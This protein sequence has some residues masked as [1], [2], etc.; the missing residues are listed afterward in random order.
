[1]SYIALLKFIGN[2]IFNLEPLEF[3][4]DFEPGLQKAIKTVYPGAKLTTCW[5]HYIRAI[6]RRCVKL[7]MRK[8]IR[9]NFNARTIQKQILNLPLLP[10]DCI[11]EG[12]NIIKNFAKEL[13]LSKKF[14]NFFKYFQDYWLKKVLFKYVM[15][16][17][18]K[19]LVHL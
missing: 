3:I 4:T 18:F 2:G 9:N 7:G 16:L 10:H 6:Q 1:M 13:K 19:S 5:F 8:L 14:Q 12:Y 11:E 17:F 15:F